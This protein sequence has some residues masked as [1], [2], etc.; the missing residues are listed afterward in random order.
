MA[1][2]LY[3]L[4][5]FQTDFKMDAPIHSSQLGDWSYTDDDDLVLGEG[6][7]PQVS[8]SVPKI[9]REAR[10]ALPPGVRAA[11]SRSP[12]KDVPLRRFDQVSCIAHDHFDKKDDTHVGKKIVAAPSIATDWFSDDAKRDKGEAQGGG[13]EDST[14]PSP[15]VNC[16]IE[17]DSP[18][19]T[20]WDGL[21]T[22]RLLTQAQVMDRLALECLAASAVS[23]GKAPR[24]VAE[25]KFDRVSTKLRY[26]PDEP[27]FALPR[28]VERLTGESKDSCY[29]CYLRDLAEKQ[30]QKKSPAA[31]PAKLSIGIESY[32]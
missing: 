21:L 16:A 23:E 11:R 32:F 7:G 29:K 3:G 5:S 2:Y 8:S 27:S 6:G 12:S 20:G 30:M 1:V 19:I 22:D 24:Y 15:K 25:G 9:S 10:K 4:G 31:A 14:P 18:C 28:E 13:A 17:E 26:F